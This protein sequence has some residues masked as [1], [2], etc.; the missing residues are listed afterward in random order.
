MD[1][2]ISLREMKK[3][4]PISYALW[5]DYV[6]PHVKRSRL[7]VNGM[8]LIFEGGPSPKSSNPVVKKIIKDGRGMDGFQ[9]AMMTWNYLAALCRHQEAKLQKK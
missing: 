9:A 7:K 4:D 2:G 8:K 1:K 5:R 3:I 6:K